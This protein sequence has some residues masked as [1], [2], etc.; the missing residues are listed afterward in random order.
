MDKELNERVRKVF[1][2]RYPH[3]NVLAEKI[4]VFKEDLSSF[5]TGA[6]DFGEKRIKKLMDHLKIN[7]TI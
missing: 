7:D 1:N 3:F 4:G 6:K 5:R 2:D